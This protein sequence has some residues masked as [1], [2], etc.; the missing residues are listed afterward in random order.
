MA[1]RDLVM[2]GFFDAVGMRL[3]DCHTRLLSGRQWTPQR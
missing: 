3:C 1:Q 2:P